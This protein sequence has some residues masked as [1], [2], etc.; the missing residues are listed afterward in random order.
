MVDWCVVV[1]DEFC[2]RFFTVEPV[3]LL[4][5]ESGPK[6]IEHE[7]LLNPE[8]RALTGELFSQTGTTSGRVPQMGPGHGYD[9]HRRRHQV[10]F[11]R[12]FARMVLEHAESLA[13]VHHVRRV[14]L[15]APARMLGYLRNELDIV[16]RH[17]I[18]VQTVSK[19]ITRHTPVGIQDILAK[20]G[21]VP[22]RK[23]PGETT[24]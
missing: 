24:T 8:G 20:E 16:T 21:L 11:G 18:L 13:R 12:H 14:V 15:A 6:L 17:K 1:A 22:C 2:A 9:D 4:G 23:R 5:L 10:E 19:D 3:D 7:D